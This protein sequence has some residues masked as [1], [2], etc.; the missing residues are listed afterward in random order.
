MAEGKPSAVIFME[1]EEEASKWVKETVE[2]F[3]DYVGCPLANYEK[4]VFLDI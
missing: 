4:Y 1:N 3:S 2:C